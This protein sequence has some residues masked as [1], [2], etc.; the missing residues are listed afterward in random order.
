MPT[1]LMKILPFLEGPALDPEQDDAYYEPSQSMQKATL[2]EHCARALDLSLETG[3]H[4]PP[5]MGSGD[6]NDGMNRVGNQGKGESVWLAWVPDRHALRIR[7]CG[8]GAG[9]KRASHPLARARHATESRG[10]SRG[11]GRGMV[12]TRLFRRWY[13]LR[14]CCQR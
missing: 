4:G 7:Q 12:P 2:F 3:S 6:W 10:G 1:Y 11:M 13:A 9:R 14:L 5:L 8:G